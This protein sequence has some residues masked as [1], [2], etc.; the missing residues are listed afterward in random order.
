M[1]C[2]RLASRWSAALEAQVTPASVS[3]LE[4]LGRLDALGRRALTCG[5]EGLR[6]AIEDM[7]EIR[8]MVLAQ[9]G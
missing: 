8:T 1:A 9:P 2:E 7:T 4:L 3:A 6:W 5:R